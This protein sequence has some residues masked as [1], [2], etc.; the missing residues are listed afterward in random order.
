MANSRVDRLDS[1][2]QKEISNIIMFD[3]D[4]KEIG[5]CTVTEVRLTGDL[6]LA[7]VYVSFMGKNYNVAALKRQKGYVRRELA[8]RLSMRKIPEIEFVVDDTLD[9]VERIT[10]ITK[11]S[12]D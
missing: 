12:H 8:H 11:K 9:K 6:S 3:L 10:E 4:T 2:L 5:F 1:I 7:R